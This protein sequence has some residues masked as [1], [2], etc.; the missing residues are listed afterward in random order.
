MY[1]YL[2]LYRYIEYLWFEVTW[3][4]EHP[5][6]EPYKRMQ[7]ML[8]NQIKDNET[9]GME[10]RICHKTPNELRDDYSFLTQTSSATRRNLCMIEGSFDGEYMWLGTDGFEGMF[11]DSFPKD[12]VVAFIRVTEDKQGLGARKKG[13]YKKKTKIDCILIS[14]TD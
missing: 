8:D 10:D 7:T 9:A 13:T 14:K 6:V 5:D 12:Q 4:R 2:N 1:I 11:N 3:L